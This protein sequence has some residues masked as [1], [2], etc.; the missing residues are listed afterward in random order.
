MP[1]SDW[2]KAWGSSKEKKMPKSVGV[3]THPCFTP[4]LIDKRA[5]GA[6]CALMLSWKDSIILRSFGKQPI[7]RNRVKRPPLL[8]KSKALVR[9]MNAMYNGRLGSRHFSCSCPNENIMSTV[10]LPARK[11]HCA[12]GYIH[13]ASISNL[14][15]T[16]R[17]KTFPTMLR[18]DI[19][20]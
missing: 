13:S 6:D 15:S 10:D 20:R 16:T 14:F 7:L 1:S 17:A 9:S 4:L 11:P 3:S 2:L 19:P 8:T 12:S 5:V 18:S